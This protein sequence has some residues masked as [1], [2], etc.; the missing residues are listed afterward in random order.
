MRRGRVVGNLLCFVRCS[1][2]NT[3]V[4]AMHEDL[5]ILK[6]RMDVLETR[7]QLDHNIRFHATVPKTK[8]N[9]GMIVKSCSDP[10]YKP[11]IF[12]HRELPVI[13]AHVMTKL[14]N[15]P[16]GLPLMRSI[17]RV[18]QT[19]RQSF[20]KLV[21]APVPTTP[22]LEAN[23]AAVLHD[24]ETRHEQVS[25]MIGVGILELQANLM[26]RRV[27]LAQGLDG[28]RKIHER[29]ESQLTQFQEGMDDLHL[30]LI[31]FNFLRSQLV[32][33]S[34][35]RPGFVGLVEKEV[36]LV[37]TVEDAVDT[38]KHLC[39]EAFGDFPDVVVRCDK[40]KLSK[41]PQIP[42]NLSYIITE[43]AKNSLRATVEA[44]MQKNSLGFVTCSDN[45]PIVITI[46]DSPE[47]QCATICVKDQGG[48]IP[49][50][51]FHKVMSYSFTT[52][53][54]A[55]DIIKSNSEGADDLTAPSTP[56]VLAGYGYGLPMSRLYARHFGGDLVLRSVE[57]VG[58]K[59]FLFIAKQM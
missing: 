2:H 6:E 18:R 11:Y 10:N 38:A 8:L 17:E 52:A 26:K 43:L 53:K 51:V 1:H 37:R 7:R 9:L 40:A 41:F 4:S 44:H 54:P 3:S 23:F 45:P 58:T 14:D 55:L 29:L 49:R 57:G 28:E 19:F 5:K 35:P 59:A 12:S 30:D 27:A 31:G 47:M 34:R 24:I 13:L 39:A 56:P 36:D 20:Q 46:S 21:D 50:S 15:L 32:S 48:G 16:M 25:P 22:E 42:T 33:L